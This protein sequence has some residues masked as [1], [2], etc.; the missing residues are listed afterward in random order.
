MSVI[1][2]IHIFRRRR[3]PPNNLKA[4]N[5][6]SFRSLLKQEENLDFFRFLLKQ[7]E[8]LDLLADD[9]PV[10]TRT[11]QEM[12]IGEDDSDPCLEQPLTNSPS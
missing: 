11:R 3:N 10:E 4:K 9:P 12:T 2:Y 1:G 5:L 7:V 6:D 8:N